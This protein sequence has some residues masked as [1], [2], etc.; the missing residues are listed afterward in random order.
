M[1]KSTVIAQCLVNSNMIRSLEEAEH[2]VR[3]VF[4]EEFPGQNFVQ[5][6][7]NL[8]DAYG[9]QIICN[10]GRASRI[11]VKCFIDDLR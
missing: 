8:D 7:S 9:E 2:A 3:R 6:N 10:V 5:W 1:R 11:N 4:D